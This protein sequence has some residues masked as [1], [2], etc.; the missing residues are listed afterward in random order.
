MVCNYESAFRLGD[1][2]KA[3]LIMGPSKT[4]I[5]EEACQLQH[6]LGSGVGAAKGNELESLHG[7]PG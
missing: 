4:S 2:L 1:A 6:K 7:F 5:I 3:V